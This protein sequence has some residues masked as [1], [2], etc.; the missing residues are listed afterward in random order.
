VKES[1][2]V[3][4]AEYAV[5]QKLATEPALLWWVPFTLKKREQIVAAVNKCYLLRSHKFGVELTK[6][7]QDALRTDEQTNTTY[8]KDALVLEIKTVDAVFKELEENE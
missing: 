3:E 6:S 5:A 2:P 7:F 1:N 8:W 4:V